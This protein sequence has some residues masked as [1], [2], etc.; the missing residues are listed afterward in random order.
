MT[1]NDFMNA[2][3]AQATCHNYI[4]AYPESDGWYYMVFLHDCNLPA[5]ILKEDR[6]STTGAFTVRVKV[7]TKAK[8]IF[9]NKAHKL[10]TVEEIESYLNDRHYKRINRG[11]CVE[12]YITEKLA[13]LEWN[14]NGK[15]FKE[16]GDVKLNGIDYQIKAHNA[17]ITTLKNLT[18]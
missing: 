6:E 11:D 4:V 14:H 18:A 5:F 7:S 1:L 2:Y 8:A 17:T 16:G 15:N 9:K 10:A 13:G 12:A 3:N